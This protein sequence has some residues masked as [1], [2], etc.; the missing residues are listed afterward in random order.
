MQSQHD[1][2]G[3]NLRARRRLGRR[4]QTTPR[5][6]VA[7][8][9]AQFVL[10]SNKSVTVFAPMIRLAGASRC[11]NQKI[12]LSTAKSRCDSH[13]TGGEKRKFK[14]LTLHLK[15]STAPWIRYV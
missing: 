11:G 7:F 13:K 2:L 9:R 3:D 15:N 1:Q 4:A 10:G 8:C 5:V 14:H 6:R 12:R